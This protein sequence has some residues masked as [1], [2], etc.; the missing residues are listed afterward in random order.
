MKNSRHDQKVQTKEKLLKTAYQEFSRKGLLATKTADIAL[1]AGVAHGSL[2]AHFATREALILA[3]IDDFGMH[4]GLKF[5][6]VMKEGSV[7]AVLKA[8][9]D[10]LQEWEPFYIQLVI[11]GPHLPAE[12]RAS[13]VNIQ[14]G[15][16]FHI[17]NALSNNAFDAPLHLIVNTWLGLIHYYLANSDLFCPSGSILTAKGPELIQF[18]VKLVKEKI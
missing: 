4:L 5:Q 14:S 12:I 10:V 9:L 18:F 2:F 16:A 7:E 8:H 11:C 1:A 17:Q 15:I 6:D 13:I 3:V